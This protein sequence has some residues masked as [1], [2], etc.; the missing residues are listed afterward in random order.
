M[1]RPLLIRNGRIIDPGRGI[2]EAGSL[3][4]NEQGLLQ[5]WES[6]ASPG[7]EFTVIEAGGLVVCPGFIDMHCHLRQPG[8]EYKETIASGTLAAARGGFTTVCC[9]P[10][11]EPPLDSP[12]TV[13]FVIDTAEREGAVRVLPIACV[14]RGRKGKVLA[15]LAELA[16]MGVAGFSDDGSP[17]YD[18][19]IMRKALE[20]CRGWGLPVIEHCEVP[21]LAGDGVINEGKVS[22]ELGLKGIPAAAEE[23]MVARDIGL[24]RETGSRVHIAH[25]STAGT[26]ELI[27]EAKAVGIGITAE[28]TP[29]HLTLTED[30]V[31]RCG[32]QAKVNPPLR[33]Q[34]DID[35]LIEGLNDGTID[36]IAT[37][38]APH[39]RYEKKGDI[40]SA[41]FGFS[42]FETALGSL[43][44]LVHSSRITLNM[45][46]DRLTRRPA[47]LLGE[48]AGISG[49]LAEGLPADAVIFDPDKEW[50]VDP[51]E[52]AS[53]GKNT[54]LAGMTLKGKVVATISKGK[55]VYEDAK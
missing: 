14:T 49:T 27:R 13:R 7:P 6:N 15:Q 24:A 8:F 41:A 32:A 19:G 10:N 28:V 51:D 21:E 18:A 30:E 55:L 43:M 44:G 48:R 45:L 3:L 38:H 5:A 46:V 34:R 26:V 11:T 50:V 39:A 4:V 9:M 17:V 12:D 35:A 40:T 53:K 31:V 42:G 54:P 23:Q 22:A 29:H 20:K 16:S 2:D 33:T 47:L 37:D 25:A 36:I 52:F 1:T